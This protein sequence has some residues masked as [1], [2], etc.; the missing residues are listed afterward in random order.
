[1]IC[2]YLG[3]LDQWEER[4]EEKQRKLTYLSVSGLLGL[5]RAERQCIFPQSLERWKTSSEV[6]T[7]LGE[8]ENTSQ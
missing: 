4:A 7:V 3:D 2:V 1:M 6:G 5:R 8:N